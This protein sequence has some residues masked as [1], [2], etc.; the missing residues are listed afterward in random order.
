VVF[1]SWPINDPPGMSYGQPSIIHLDG[2]GYQVLSEANSASL[3]APGPDGV[4]LA[5]DLGLVG[6]VQR[7]GQ[8]AQPFDLAAFGLPGSQDLAI[9]SPAWSPDGQKLAWWVSGEVVSAGSTHTA[10]AIFDLAGNSYVLLHP[11]IPTGGGGWP[12]NPVWSPDGQWLAF[13]TRGEG[14]KSAMYIGRDDGSLEVD[15]GD[16]TNPVWSPQGDR[17]IYTSWPP[18]NNSYLSAM[19]MLLTVADGQSR[20]LFDFPAGSTPNNW[21]P[22]DR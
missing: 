14:S 2:S 8:A 19:T 6:Y 15:L 22:I 3:P 9:G 5:Y 12:P 16:S 1:N 21:L 4:T 17:L 13:N 11:Y 7:L 10:L 20:Q 18:E